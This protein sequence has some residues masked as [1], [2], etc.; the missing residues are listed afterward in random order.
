MIIAA[1][2]GTRMKSAIPKVLHQVCGRPILAYVIDAALAVQPERLVV[3]SAPDHD[4]VAGVLPEGAERA[5]QQRRLGTGDAARAGLE[6]LGDFAGDVMVLNGDHPLTTGGF[7]GG[8]LAAHRREQPAATIGT[9]TLADAAQYGRILRDE[10]GAVT[11]IIEFRDA[12]PVQ[13][14]LHE[15]NIG[16]YV[17][18]AAALRAALPRLTPQ[19]AQ[20]EYYLTDVIRLALDDGRRVATF[21]TDD[22]GVAMGVNSRV[23]LAEVNGAMRAR[24]LERL[25]LAGVTVE[26]PLSTYVDWGVEVGRDTVLRPQCHLLG[27]TQVGAA[28]DIGPGTYLKDAFVHDRARVVASHLVEC[29]VGPNA[30][31]GPFTYLRPGTQLDES[32]KAGAFVEIKNSRVGTRSKVPHLSYVGDTT[33]GTDTNIG[34]GNITANYDGFRKHRTEIGSHVH[35]GS[36]TVFVAPV[37][38]GDHAYTG[39][40]SIITKDIPAGALG[41]AREQQTNLEGYAERR[42][43]LEELRREQEARRVESRDGDASTSGP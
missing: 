33:V 30:N 22:G 26:D 2:L 8:L 10:H 40:G 6:K 23:E 15:V 28:C 35:T 37:K 27:D 25:M 9:V 7:T 43:R 16:S 11:G 34:C 19:N 36:D 4:A 38:V 41:V 13:R 20:G 39:A 42:E 32:A 24:L 18:A 31:V 14:A 17:F 29:E 1:G 5:V 3:V 21:T 12:T